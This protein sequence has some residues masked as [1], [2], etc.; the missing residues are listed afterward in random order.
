MANLDNIMDYLADHITS[1]F[2]EAIDVYVSINDTWTCPQNG[3][4]VMLCTRIGAKNNTIW[5][6]QDLTANIYAIGAL[7]SYISAGTSVTT[8]F[9]VIK[10]HVY[11]NIYEDGVTDAHLYY[12]K[13]K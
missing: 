12:Y 6:I 8:S 5:Y 13:I 2:E 7:N 10:G 9:P 4:V 3:I 11:K 1:P